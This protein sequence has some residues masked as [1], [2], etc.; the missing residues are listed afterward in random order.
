[1]I[2]LTIKRRRNLFDLWQGR[3]L[4]IAGHL[5]EAAKGKRRYF[6]PRR[7][8]SH[9]FKEGMI[10]HFYRCISCGKQHGDNESASGCCAFVQEIY[11][12]ENCGTEFPNEGKA[13]QHVT[14]NPLTECEAVAI[15]D[16]IDR[17]A[18]Q[19]ARIRQGS[20]GSFVR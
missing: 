17:S 3:R 15:A 16:D 12:C 20:A 18:I 6:S 5:S 19:A 11:R 8:G 14:R 2:P 9:F 13:N 7:G 4:D 10:S 1:M